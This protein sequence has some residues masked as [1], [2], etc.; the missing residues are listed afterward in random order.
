MEQLT[1]PQQL[2][3]S[4]TGHRPNKLNQEYYHDGPLSKALIKQFWNIFIMYRPTSIISGM[5][6]GAD[7][8]W[9]MAAIYHGIPFTAA[10]P[11][12]GQ[13]LKWTQKNQIKYHNI[14]EKASRVVVVSEGGYSPAKMQIR[15]EWMVDNSQRLVAVHNGTAGGTMNCIEYARKKMTLDQITFINPDLIWREIKVL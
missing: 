1:Q 9:A 4:C 11:F 13:E 15:N 3:I 10:V 14:L 8:L 6:L 5:A 12:I 7:Q 2:V